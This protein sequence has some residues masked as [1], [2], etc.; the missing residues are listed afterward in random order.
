MRTIY[1]CYDDSCEKQIIYEEKKKKKEKKK[2][3]DNQ[4][5][6]FSRAKRMKIN[7]SQRYFNCD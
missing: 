4:D 5:T 2:M 7:N 3:I 6:Y 1:D